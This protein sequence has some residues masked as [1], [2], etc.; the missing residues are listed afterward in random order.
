MK[1]ILVILLLSCVYSFGQDLK[2]GIITL[3]D[4]ELK[5]EDTSDDHDAILILNSVDVVFVDYKQYLSIRQR[6]RIET[7][8]G[9]D[10]ATQSIQLY[11][12]DSGRETLKNLSGTTY[13]LT[14]GKVEKVELDVNSVFEED[15]SE[16]YTL[17][18]F[19]M[20]DVRIGSIIEF[21]YVVESPFP[22][23]D[24]INLQYGIPIINLA[25][26][27]QFPNYY[28][29]NVV[30]NPKSRYKI[31]FNAKDFEDSLTSTLIDASESDYFD[32]DQK[33]QQ[34][35]VS[36]KSI[37]FTQ[38]HIPALLP[39]F[40]SGNL[41]KYR[42]KM[43]INIASFN[44]VQ[45]G[46]VRKE[47][48]TTWEAVAKTIY[49]SDKFG[50]EVKRSRFFRKDLEDLTQSLTTPKEKVTAILD[51]LK[52]KVKWD[53]KYGVF[54]KDGIKEAYK[55]GS[56]NVSEVNLL[57]VSM[58]REAEIEANPVLVSSVDNETP[59]FPTR[60][61]FNYIVVQVSYGDEKVL[62]DATEKFAGLNLLPIR[63]ANWK[64][65][66]IKKDGSS[67]WIRLTDNQKSED[68]VFLNIKLDSESEA[69]GNGQKRHTNYRALNSRNTNMNS[70]ED[71]LEKHIQNDNVGLEISNV[72][73]EGLENVDSDLTYKYDIKFKNAFDKV[74][75]NIYITPL[76]YEA[77]EESPFK[78]E[79]RKLPLDL[80][81]PYKTKTIVNIKIPEGY[82]VESIPESIKAVYNDTI[83]YYKYVTRNQG[84]MISTVATFNLDVSVIQPKDYP[85]FKKFFEAIVEK[86]AQKIVLKKI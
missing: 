49:D 79:T 30:F 82:E 39:E 46:K 43:I 81:F 55:K 17:K 76:L 74:G 70:T 58:L 85:A 50:D 51:F 14:D 63:A 19:T 4:F 66:L 26:N 40:L 34:V 16:F 84:N 7:E 83:G 64:G 59:I 77:N 23:I 38:Q 22:Y 6:I 69:S 29:Y 21:S 73:V 24:D 72:I 41:N 18:S 53:G 28:S 12:S 31:D 52:L 11:Q 3:Q 78:L 47:F 57:L 86:D 27:I 71:E 25:L 45:T 61:G 1:N 62:V 2:S 65:R 60:E 44:D 48:G 54:T 10:Y 42:A 5:T 15:L 33:I 35:R 68:I 32:S 37:S 20:P 56:G 75:D 80:S 67:E 36:N 9:L 13:N 8:K